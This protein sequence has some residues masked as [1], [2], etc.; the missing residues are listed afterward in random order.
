MRAER[1]AAL[2]AML[3]LALIGGTYVVTQL[4]RQDNPFSDCLEGSVAGG[5]IGGPFT[6]TNHLGQRVSDTDVITGPTLV[7]FGY[8]FCPDVCPTDLAR[9]AIA[10]DILETQGIELTPV[11]IT[12]DPNRDQGTDLANFVS[13]FHPRLIGLTGSGEEIARAART[14]K[15]Y[16]QKQDGD[17]PE[18]YLMDHSSFSYLMLP[19]HGF[20]DFFRSDEPA[21]Q[22]AE[23]IACVVDKM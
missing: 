18:Y 17:D 11:F 15:A 10:T 3:V 1:V 22:V 8:S 19:D 13:S 2:A 21:D 9:N 12:I 5:N 20:I 14:Y 23:R 7:Y 6:L 4:N 16:Y